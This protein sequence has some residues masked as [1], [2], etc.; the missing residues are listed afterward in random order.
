[1]FLKSFKS[2]LLLATILQLSG[3]TNTVIFKSDFK[4][5]LNTK[6]WKVETQK[7]EEG[8]SVFMEDG[9]L[10][11]DSKPGVTVW[12][13]KE[14]SG[15]Y[16]ISYDRVVVLDSGKNDR[17]SDLNQFWMA[18][19][20]P[21][22]R[23]GVFEEYDN[24]RLYYIGYGGNY[25]STTRFRKYEGNGIKPVLA[26]YLE[27][28]YLLKPNHTYRI[29]TTVQDGR[30]TLSVDGEVLVDYLDQNPLEK[31]YFGFRTTWSRQK[32]SNL[33]IEKI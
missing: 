21:F 9:F 27:P 14:L 19:A 28:K 26:E 23:E 32:I 15:N 7:E 24:V 11:M 6:L 25:N 2:V 31:G 4:G 3:C 17:L 29:I 22:D 5:K 12:L 10:V 18:E 20:K 16:R 13:N 30:I 33:R 1:M 8:S